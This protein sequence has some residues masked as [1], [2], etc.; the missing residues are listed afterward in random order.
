MEFLDNSTLISLWRTYS[1]LDPSIDRLGHT[2]LPP[3]HRIFFPQVRVFT[4]PNPLP[5]FHWIRRRRVDTG[6]HPYLLKAAFP[7][8]TVMYLEDWEDYHKLQFPFVIERIVIADREA[9]EAA[10]HLGQPVY[11]P[12]FEL[13]ASEFWWEPVRR[14]LA[15]YFDEV[16]EKAGKKVVTYLHRQGEKTGLWLRDED[17]QSLVGALKSLGRGYEVHIVS[18]VIDE[19]PWSEKLGAIVKSSV[20]ALHYMTPCCLNIL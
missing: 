10:V 13:K 11:A 14:T 16:D 8:L 7:H 9:A 6:F 4:D 1:S 3:P 12:P 2:T 18:S 19:T 15:A 5:H 20:S 17:H